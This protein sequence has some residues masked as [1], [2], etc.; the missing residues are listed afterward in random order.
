MKCLAN[1]IYYNF[2]QENSKITKYVKFPRTDVR[3]TQDN[4][5]E[6][7]GEGGRVVWKQRPCPGL[8]KL[9]CWTNVRVNT[10]D[11]R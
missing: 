1:K 10:N 3:G 2:S 6:M 8:R 9:S 5:N 4:V 11:V 7:R